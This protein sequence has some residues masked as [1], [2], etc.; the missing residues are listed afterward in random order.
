MMSRTKSALLQFRLLTPDRWSDLEK[1]FGERGACSGCWCMYWRVT[2]SE[3]DRLRDDGRKQTFQRIVKSG[4][5]AGILAYLNDEPVGWCSIAPRETFGALE[6]SRTL[7]R[8]DDRPVWSIV[9]FFVARPH[10]RA[11]LMIELLRAA[12][13]HAQEHGAKIV[14]GYPVEL[15]DRRYAGVELYTGVASV[16]HE[17]GFI[18]VRRQPRL[19]MRHFSQD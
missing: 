1:L 18:E 17:A 6:R 16:F 3:F 7:K 8:V 10:R 5:I 15:K 13:E 2:R 4:E 9:C 14:E 12:I 19:I 11:G